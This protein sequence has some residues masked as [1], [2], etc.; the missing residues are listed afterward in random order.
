MLVL[1]LLF[2]VVKYHFFIKSLNLLDILV[3]TIATFV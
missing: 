2:F 3:D 1:K